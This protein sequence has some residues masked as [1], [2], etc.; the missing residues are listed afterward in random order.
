[1]SMSIS[2]GSKLSN[3]ILRGEEREAALR[4]AHELKQIPLTEV[5]VSD[6]EMIANGAMSP[7]TGFMTKADYDS[8]VQSMR[9]ANGLIWSVP[10]KRPADKK[11]AVDLGVG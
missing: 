7:L 8:V 2:H 11:V 10:I 4:R 5:G 9:L 3:R 1:M 6:L